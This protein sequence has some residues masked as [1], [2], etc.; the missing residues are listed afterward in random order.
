MPITRAKASQLLNQREMALYDDSRINGL[1][2]L[3]GR[4]LATRVARARTARDRARDLVRR[5]KLAS[6][7]RTGS[8][9]GSSGGANQR[10]K[11]KAELL[12]DI[13]DR[14]ETRLR[15]VEGTAGK[16][17]KS[18]TAKKSRGGT[19]A[20]AARSTATTKAGSRKTA[21]ST[22][23]TR[24]TRTTKTTKTAGVSGPAKPATA[25]G[26]STRPA[27]ASS[28]RRAPPAPAKTAR[29]PA[30]AKPAGNAGS[31]ASE[32]TRNAAGKQGG[33]KAGRSAAAKAPPQDGARRRSRKRRITPEEAL[34]QTQALLEAKQVRDS[35]PKPWEDIGGTGPAAGEPGYQSASAE[36]RARRLHAAEIRL[37]ANQGSIST[38]DRVNQGK[39]DH[40]G[41]AD[42]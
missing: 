5:Q 25:T 8:K 2:Q 18:A 1:R 27:A 24:T 14:F 7:E 3:D 39:R 19:P 22:K 21:T 28:T 29:Q 9:R 6:R 4:A 13:L 15:E 34:A 23:A 42:D 12:A 10:S 33:G 32:A 38:R 37:P 26:Q 31:T 30:S 41:Q 20:N 17:R 11:D 40:R 35:E 16:A 36:R